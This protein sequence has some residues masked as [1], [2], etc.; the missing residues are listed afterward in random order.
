MAVAFFDVT[1]R[2]RAEE[3]L[4]ESEEK[5]RSLVDDLTVGV[6]RAEPGPNG[7]LLFAN[8]ALLRISGF[9]DL[10]EIN[11][12]PLAEHFVNPRDK[13]ALEDLVLARGRQ[14]GLPVELKR[15]GGE[16]IWASCS[17][18][19]FRDQTQKVRHLDGIL[20]DIT[21]RK[22][23]DEA[24]LESEERFR[25][26]AEA[27]FEGIVIT[28]RGVVLDANRRLAEM[29]GSALPELIG[30]PAIEF[31][32]PPSR[33]MVKLKMR[34]GHD[35]PYE[36]LAQRRD[37]SI[38]PV[39]VHGRSIPFE[40]RLA[41]ITAIRDISDRKAAEHRLRVFRDLLDRSSDGILVA[42]LATRQVLD[43]NDMTCTMLGLSREEALALTL[44]A[45]ERRLELP[46]QGRLTQALGQKGSRLIEVEVRRDDGSR[47][48]V[49]VNLRRVVE[50]DH[51]YLV[52]IARDVSE[53]RQV[54]SL[55]KSLA[56][57][58]LMSAMGRLVGGVAHEV[59]NPLF[60][61]SATLDAFEQDF[62][63]HPDY[64]EYARLLRVEVDRLRRLMQDLL[65]YGRP[66]PETF[67]P[68]ALEAVIRESVAACR[69]AAEK[70]G[71]TVA[72]EAPLGLPELRMSRARMGQVFENLV[73]NALDHAPRG[74]TVRLAVSTARR[75]GRGV[76]RCAIV[77]EGPGFAANDIPM[78]FEPFFTRR[79]GGT[80]LGLSIVQRVVEEH[81][82]Q[83]RA[84]NR[85][86]GGAEVTVELPLPTRVAP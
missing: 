13:A 33:E 74:S 66:M 2:K 81:D 59:R 78:L 56:R 32:A 31:V 48:P 53:R 62:A 17:L 79:K 22:R 80:G 83:V 35:Q 5:Y 1:E 76:V 30:T 60:A 69:V 57:N 43:V 73:K 67:A 63:Q 39:E 75:D 77:D 12:K 85:P 29:F 58:E 55:Q 68:A 15:K 9:R 23:A 20:E 46:D 50:A 41:R 36:H 11:Q 37:G 45:L 72:L 34:S 26:L 64:E 54:E 82:G 25:R 28:D 49:E 42:D 10:A 14:S 16:T 71:V 38:F 65:D 6:F 27:A 7:R 86:G 18:L 51:D 84:A 52:G 44:E 19:A 40:G 3:A 70:A 8:R 24:V 47:L 4:R 21:E 61:I